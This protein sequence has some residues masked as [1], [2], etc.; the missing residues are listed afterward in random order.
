M[1]KNDL[2][3]NIQCQHFS[4]ICQQYLVSVAV[5]SFSEGKLLTCIYKTVVKAM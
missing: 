5:C 3:V 4:L 1:S 2:A